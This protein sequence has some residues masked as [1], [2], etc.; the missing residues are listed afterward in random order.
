MGSITNGKEYFCTEDPHSCYQRRDPQDAWLRFD[1]ETYMRQE[2]A[3]TTEDASPLQL[4]YI[5]PQMKGK[6]RYRTV[7]SNVNLLRLRFQ[8]S[9]FPVL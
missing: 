9:T 8:I 6:V 1:P 4:S 7:K 5:A 3:L 2:G